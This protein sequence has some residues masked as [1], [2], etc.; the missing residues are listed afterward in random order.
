MFRVSPKGMGFVLTFSFVVAVGGAPLFAATVLPGQSTVEGKTL[1]QWSSEWWKWAESFGPGPFSDTTGVRG[2]VNQ[3]GPV[4]YLAGSG[5]NAGPITRTITVGS[6]KYVLLPLINWIVAAGAD[7]GFADTRSEANALATNT[8]NPANLFATIDGVPV[9]NLASHREESGALFTLPVVANND[10]GFPPG[11]Y[12]DAYSDG[13]W[14]MVAPLSAGPHTLH[15]GGT[16]SFYNAGAFQVDPF[17]IDVT[18]NLNAVPLPPAHFVAP[19]GVAC[20]AAWRRRYA[21]RG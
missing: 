4:F 7:P 14:L 8:I 11:T 5:G 6:D 12:T 21:R 19:V 17:T 15:F 18:V 3:G 2:N 20:A 13:Y 16:G 1:G 9:G 10:S